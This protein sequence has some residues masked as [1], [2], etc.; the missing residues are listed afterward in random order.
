MPRAAATA[1]PERLRQW[2]A[3]VVDII[4]QMQD[5]TVA[6]TRARRW[7]TR[8][9]RAAAH[10]ADT[11]RWDEMRWKW[12]DERERRKKRLAW[13]SSF[14]AHARTQP[15][16]RGG[17]WR[18]DT[19][20]LRNA[21]AAREIRQA[22]ATARNG[23][24]AALTRQATGN[25]RT[26]NMT[27]VPPSSVH[28]A[29]APPPAPVPAPAPTTSTPNPRNTPRAPKRPRPDA[30]TP[31]VHV[32]M[33]ADRQRWRKGAELPGGKGWEIE[34]NYGR[35][36]T[37]DWRTRFYVRP[38]RALADLRASRPAPAGD[39]S[40]DDNHDGDA[41]HGL[42]T[43]VE[44]PANQPIVVYLG[45]DVGPADDGDNSDAIMRELE[46]RGH[47]R[48]VMSMHTHKGSGLRLID[49]LDE[50]CGAQYINAAHGIPGHTDNARFGNTG[51]INIRPR[52]RGENK[53]PK[54]FPIP[55]N[56]ELLMAYGQRY[57]AGL[58]KLRTPTSPSDAPPGGKRRARNANSELAPQK[59]SKCRRR[60][61]DAPAPQQQHGSATPP[62]CARALDASATASRITT[63]PLHPTPVARATAKRARAESAT[64]ETPHQQHTHAARRTRHSA[65]PPPLVAPLPN[66]PSDARCKRNNAIAAADSNMH[67]DDIQM[68]PTKDMDNNTARNGKR[69]RTDDDADEHNRQR[70]CPPARRAPTPA[71]PPPAA[72]AHPPPSSVPRRARGKR[73]SPRK[74]LRDS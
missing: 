43:A 46:Q 32:D 66:A 22:R 50:I 41:G 74:K 5:A 10:T 61:N 28:P 26:T 31:K 11:R 67:K 64:H 16:F 18:V 69:T 65:E 70:H 53:P 63:R 34:F 44:L 39:G 40:P 8:K 62:A 19:E 59:K 36:G 71:A 47:E 30:R 49:G 56:T 29:T 48:H 27:T 35:H 6:V 52:S 57:W 38:S 42:Y 12:I 33:L 9:A 4:L 7:I 23:E 54:Q 13:A 37:T 2:E 15:G 60:S 73:K 68:F 20:G 45:S 24:P 58:A 51:T 3:Q 17:G 1:S 14:I 21:R 55:A 25:A 72:P